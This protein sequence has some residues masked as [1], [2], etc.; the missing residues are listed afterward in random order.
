MT[1]KAVAQLAV[2]LMNSTAHEDGDANLRKSTLKADLEYADAVRALRPFLRLDSTFPAALD[3]ST[4]FLT[5]A[6]ECAH[7]KRPAKV[8]Q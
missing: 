7:L 8:M 2:P 4:Q 1:M 6:S 3:A 5:D